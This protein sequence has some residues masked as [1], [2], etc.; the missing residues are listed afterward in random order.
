MELVRQLA[1]AFPSV[2]EDRVFGVSCVASGSGGGHDGI[3]AFL[4]G[5]TV[6]FRQMTSPAGG[7]AAPGMAES[8]HE[9][10]GAT[11]RQRLLIESCLSHLD[12]FLEMV[13]HEGRQMGV[14][15]VDVVAMA[16]E[17][18]SAADCLGRITGRGEGSGDVEE[19]LGVVFEKFCVGK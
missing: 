17:L 13:G 11:H 4:N 7:G 8:M 9:S 10:I 19:V 16:E 18:R 5:L 2:K 14:D 3:Q 6:I 12:D 15:E 1:F